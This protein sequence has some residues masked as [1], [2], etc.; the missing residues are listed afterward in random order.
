MAPISFTLYC[1]SAPLHLCE[2]NK[3][4]EM[5]LWPG[6]FIQKTGL[7]VVGATVGGEEKEEEEEVWV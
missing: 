3:D 1:S 4:K 7:D 5:K 2:C 6:I